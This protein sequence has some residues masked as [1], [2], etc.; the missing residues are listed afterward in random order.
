MGSRVSVQ[1]LIRTERESFKMRTKIFYE[2]EDILVVRKPAGIAVQTGH[3][4]QQDVESELKNHLAKASG[5]TGGSP[6]LGVIHRLDQP[7]E[8]LLVFAKNKKAAAALSAQLTEGDFC[9][10]YTAAVWG[11]PDRKQEEGTLINFLTK[12]G[13]RALITETAESTDAKRAVLRYTKL[14]DAVVEGEKISLLRIRLE[15]GR[16]HQ[17][18]AQ[19]SH[20]GMPILGD[21]AYGSSESLAFSEN[22]GITRPALC[23]G[24]LIF[25]HPVTGAEMEYRTDSDNPAF[26]IFD[27]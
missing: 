8:G 13:N 18:R 9:K 27:V 21:R 16:F 20:A 12:T 14:A 2:D 3:I 7:V 19:L 24:H 15:T 22:Q 5:S 1:D 25:Y 26:S 4:G 10:E 6:Y 17:I 11:G 23:A